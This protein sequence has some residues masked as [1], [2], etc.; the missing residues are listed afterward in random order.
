MIRE[1]CLFCYLSLSAPLQILYS[2]FC[3]IMYQMEWLNKTL[4]KCWPYIDQVSV[5]V[6]VILFVS[7][8]FTYDDMAALLV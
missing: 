4:T 3:G 1:V 5:G 8:Q 7:Q 6:G 2:M